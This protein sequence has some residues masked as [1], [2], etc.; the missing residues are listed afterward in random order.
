[1]QFDR[2]SGAK[3]MA[4]AQNFE[5][6]LLGLLLCP[7]WSALRNVRLLLVFPLPNC[8]CVVAL[9]L[10]SNGLLPYTKQICALPCVML[11]CL[12]GGNASQG[13]W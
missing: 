8:P 7:Y 13:L 6:A 12:T 10:Y 11:H 4:Q 2:A 9:A 3:A 1:M 5:A